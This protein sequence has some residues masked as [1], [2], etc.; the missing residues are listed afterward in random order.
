MQ[1]KAKILNMKYDRENNLF[2]LIIQDVENNKQ[3]GIAIRG[4]DWGITQDIPEDIIEKFCNDMKGKEKNL[5]IEIDKSSL[6]DAKKNEDG[7]TTQEEIDRINSNIDSYPINE[8][9]N[10]LHKENE[11]EEV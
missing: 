10:V 1:I 9:M 8:I 5:F 4:T 3:T 7:S 6:R 11:N 2:Q